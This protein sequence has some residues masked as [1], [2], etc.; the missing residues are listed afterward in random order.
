MIGEGLLA[1]GSGDGETPDNPADPFSGFRVSH[2]TASASGKS[3]TWLRRAKVAGFYGG[4]MTFCIDTATGEFLSLGSD[5]NDD[6]YISISTA[7]LVLSNDQRGYADAEMTGARIHFRT[8][9]ETFGDEFLSDFYLHGGPFGLKLYRADQYI[10]PRI[11][12]YMDR[13]ADGVVTAKHV[14]TYACDSM[15]L[16]TIPSV[17]GPQTWLTVGMIQSLT[18]TFST[19]AD[20]FKFTKSVVVDRADLRVSGAMQFVQFQDA[21]PG[22]SAWP[23][24]PTSYGP[25]EAVLFF[26]QAT[27][28]LYL[29]DTAE[30]KELQFVA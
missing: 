30:W 24:R 3:T 11:D 1:I 5:D 28:K 8:K 12:L 29:W 17:V 23:E 27:K 6:T 4:E 16:R 18:P 15:T 14:S 20:H 2:S 9:Y 21:I 22:Y 25:E 26:D 19:N 10:Q 13:D 7:D